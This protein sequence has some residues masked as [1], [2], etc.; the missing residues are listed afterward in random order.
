MDQ[1]LA[2]SY[3]DVKALLLR[4][5]KLTP[6]AYLNRYQTATKKSD[7]TYV[8]F[9]NRLSTLLKYYASSRDVKTFDNLIS[10]LIA[11]HVKPML[12]PDCL[13]HIL[14]VE[15]TTGSFHGILIH[16]SQIKNVSISAQ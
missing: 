3:K 6:W 9:V 4:E 12:P 14:A 8:I 10:L 13:K 2:L 1:K 16:H 15:N 7:E 11:D 5:Y